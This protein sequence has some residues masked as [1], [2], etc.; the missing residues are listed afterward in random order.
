MAW[1][2]GMGDLANHRDLLLFTRSLAAALDFGNVGNFVVKPA[3]EI[4]RRLDQDQVRACTCAARVG[5][6]GVC[7]HV[8]TSWGTR[9]R[10]G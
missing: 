8:W 7:V 10:A 4:A 6:D 9:R 3:P 2:Q 1:L 5:G